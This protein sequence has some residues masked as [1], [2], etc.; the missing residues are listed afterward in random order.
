MGVKKIARPLNKTK[1]LFVK[2]LKDRNATDIDDYEGIDSNGWDY[3]RSVSGFVGDTLY[4]VVFE[5][6]NEKIIIDYS[7]GENHYDRM[8][9]DD[10]TQLLS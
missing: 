8:T 10:F 6:W 7:D 1:N 9:I 4:L 3:Y 5:M 2:W